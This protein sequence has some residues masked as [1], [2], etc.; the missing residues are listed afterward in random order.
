MIT[1]H[2]NGKDYQVDENSDESLMQQLNAQGAEIVSA[3]NG[4]GICQ[5]CSFKTISG[6]FTSK[7]ETEE[8]MDLPEGQRLSCQ[9]KPTAN[10]EIEMLY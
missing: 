6:E 1:I 9:C 2:L 4:A 7:T 3:C 8:M 5:S 10:G